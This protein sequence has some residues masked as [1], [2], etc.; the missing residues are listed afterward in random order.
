MD[1]LPFSLKDSFCS[2]L[3]IRDPRQHVTLSSVSHLPCDALDVGERDALVV[4]ADDKL[5]EVVPQ[6]L[7][8]HAHM[9][10]IDTADLEVIQKLHCLVTLWIIL[11]RLSNLMSKGWHVSCVY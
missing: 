7:K 3:P 8:H 10:P 11:V 9:S 5:E 4:R 6:D 2:L 1:L